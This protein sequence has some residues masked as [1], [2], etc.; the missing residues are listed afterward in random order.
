MIQPGAVISTST[1]NHVRSGTAN[2]TGWERQDDVALA[3]SFVTL[4]GRHVALRLVVS[5]RHRHALALASHAALQRQRTMVLGF[6]DQ[7]QDLAVP[8]PEEQ[9]ATALEM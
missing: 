9:A 6:A 3:G 2:S 8:Q 7:R 4:A 5:L 1:P